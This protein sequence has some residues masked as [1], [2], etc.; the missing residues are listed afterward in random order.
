[1][2]RTKAGSSMDEFWVEVSR[3]AYEL[4][5]THGWTALS[6]A[7][8]MAAEAAA[9]D[10]PGLLSFGARSVRLFDGDFN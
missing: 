2:D 10:D 7:E 6:Y 8:R 5:V 9:A 1:M 4:S 3:R